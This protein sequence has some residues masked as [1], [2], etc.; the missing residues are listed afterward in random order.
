MIVLKFLMVCNYFIVLLVKGV[1]R[2][3]FIKGVSMSFLRLI[4]AED[5]TTRVVIVFNT[6][7]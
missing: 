7:L 4:A 2:L 1:E 6:Y 3:L 5:S